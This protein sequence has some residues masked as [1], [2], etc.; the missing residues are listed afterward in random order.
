V[1][2]SSSGT[3]YVADTGNNRVQEWLAGEPP[4]FATSFTP[5]NIEGSF[6]EPD[7]VA[8]DPS[9]NIWVADSGHNRVLE[10]NSNREF[11]RQVGTEGTGAGQF[12]GIQGIAANSSGDVY[13]TGSDRVQEFSPTGEFLRQFGAPG[14]GNGQ[15][16]GPNG[17]AVDGSGNVWVVDTFNY[18]VQE[19]SASGAYLGQLGSKGTGNGQ[20]GWASGL[21]FAGG[22]LYVADSARVEEF[23]TSGAFIAQFGSAGTGNGQFHGLGGIASDPTTGNLYVSDMANNR[24]QEFSSSGAFIGFIAAFGSAG[25]GNG[26]FSGARGVAVNSSGT[27]YVADSGNNRVQEWVPSPRGPAKQLAAPM[28]VA[29]PPAGFSLAP[30]ARD[31]PTARATVTQVGLGSASLS[32]RSPTGHSKK[33][34]GSARRTRSRNARRLNGPGSP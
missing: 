19:F 13:V 33:K 20:L 26:Q 32:W 23:S 11:L 5:E 17:V 2:V 27:L 9:G 6:K 10:F 31:A 1:A 15:F 28:V 3:L 25:S 8:L 22:N 12:E 29:T 24:V 34:A 7:A 16:L 30:T 4:T 21:A 14:S 18:R